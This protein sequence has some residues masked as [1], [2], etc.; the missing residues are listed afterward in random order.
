NSGKEEHDKQVGGIALTGQFSFIDRKEFHERNKTYKDF[1][2]LPES[3]KAAEKAT[4][5][6]PEPISHHTEASTS[7]LVNPA[8]EENLDR[9]N[10]T[11]L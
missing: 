9:E 8:A 4:E 11:Q 6:K 5:T 1:P 3:W 2:E 7:E 10:K